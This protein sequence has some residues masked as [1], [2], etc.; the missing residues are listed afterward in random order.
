MPVLGSRRFRH[1][2]VVSVATRV[3]RQ[4]IRGTPIFLVNT[5]SKPG[6]RPISTLMHTIIRTAGLAS[7]G[8]YGLIETYFE[9]EVFSYRLEVFQHTF[10]SRD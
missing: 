5:S 9:D 10:D 6:K 3:N 8:T 2:L 4:K 1:T 7:M